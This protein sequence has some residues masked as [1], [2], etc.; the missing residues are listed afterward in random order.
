MPQTNA[1]PTRFAQE[2]CDVFD[3]ALHGIGRRI[4]TSASTSTVVGEDG[5]V[6]CHELSQLPTLTHTSVAERA[7]DQNHRRS[8]TDSI[9]CYRRAVL[10]EHFSHKRGSRRLRHLWGSPFGSFQNC[11]LL[12]RSSYFVF[13]SAP[14][15]SALSFNMLLGLGDRGEVFREVFQGLSRAGIN[16]HLEQSV[17]ILVRGALNR[18]RQHRFLP[19]LGEDERPNRPGTGRK[20][21][22]GENYLLWWDDFSIDARE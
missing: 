19:I 2:R 3:L 15:K 14:K 9:E 10:R 4:T 22:Y 7:V 21:P 8:F 18:H 16:A 17:A 20:H 11:H 12:H 1:A 6:L 13:R 5:E